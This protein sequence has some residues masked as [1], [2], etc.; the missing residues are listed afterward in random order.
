MAAVWPS[1]CRLGGMLAI[2]SL[3]A[4]LIVSPK[5][6]PPLAGLL[7]DSRPVNVIVRFAEPPTAE[8]HAIIR[9][10]GGVMRREFAFIKSASYRVRGNTINEIASDP[11]VVY[12]SSDGP[13]SNPVLVTPGK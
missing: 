7:D 11:R 9:L 4:A 10:Q 1:A 3:L 2:L 12:I 6:S 5:I 8:L 13:V